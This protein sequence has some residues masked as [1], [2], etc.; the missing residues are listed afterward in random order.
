MPVCIDD[1]S[2]NYENKESWATGWGALVEGG[3]ASRKLYQV[4]LPILT[5][6]RCVQK[7]RQS[8]QTV[9]VCAG[10]NAGIDTCQGDS[11]GPL[12]VR[13]PVDGKWYNHGVTSYGYGCGDG[14]VYARTG[15][16]KDWIAE[17]IRNN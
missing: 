15:A 6:A 11:G 10:D 2:I 4:K 1:G 12:V 9:E 7:Y 14:G 5:K 3:S 8:N 17:T 13:N 16:F